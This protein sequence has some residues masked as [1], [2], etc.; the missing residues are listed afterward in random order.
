M[1]KTIIIIVSALIICIVIY[2][3][4]RKIYYTNLYKKKMYEDRKNKDSTPI[5]SND[6]IELKNILKIPSYEK[7]LLFEKLIQ[8]SLNVEKVDDKIKHEISD[9][10]KED[11]KDINLVNK[12]NKC[13]TKEELVSVLKEENNKINKEKN[14]SKKDRTKR[15]Y[16]KRSK[17]QKINAE[18][19]NKSLLTSSQAQSTTQ[20]QNIA[21]TAEKVSQGSQY[22]NYFNQENKLDN[23]EKIKEPEIKLPNN[24][25]LKSIKELVE[26]LRRVDEKTY[27]YYLE[28]DSKH[29]LAWLREITGI[30]YKEELYKIKKRED[31]IKLLKEN[32]VESL[33]EE[34]LEIKKKI[35]ELRKKGK[36][37]K[38][39]DI[40]ATN[41][42]SKI[43]MAEATLEE[44]DVENAK[45]MIKEIKENLLK[46]ED[47]MKQEDRIKQEDKQKQEDTTKSKDKS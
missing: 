9:K 45:S 42:P 40:R 27:K 28:N 38:L 46:L 43:Q 8:Y 4:Y 13:K 30:N 17:E 15:K 31:L 20:I 36:D 41:I 22:T 25:E 24:K 11:I 32:L 34:Y 12:I 19:E 18:S 10:I 21:G 26:F 39:I 1:I 2:L 5:F 6:G 16:T 47:Q 29:F 7:T 23:S 33:K 44:K 14:I 3:I 35:S 37:V